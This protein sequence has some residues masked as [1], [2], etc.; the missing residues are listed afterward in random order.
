[1]KVKLLEKTPVSSE[2]I[3]E[4][5]N[6]TSK[7]KGVLFTSNDVDMD[8]RIVSIRLGEVE[9]E[10]VLV[11]PTTIKT[12]E[13]PVVYFEKDSTKNKT[14]KT[15]RFTYLLVETDNLGQVEFK[16]EKESWKDIDEFMSDAG[17][18]ECVLAQRGIDAINGMDITHPMIAY[19]PAVKSPQKVGR[20]ER[21]MIQSPEGES[22]FIKYKNARQY[23]DNGYIML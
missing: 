1:M 9:D 10:L 23:L 8:K 2:D 16:S 12:S 7:L 14:R 21:V 19:N 11:N 5:K 6:R 4:Y 3:Q 15:V 13:K 22:M 17:L 18:F 20:N